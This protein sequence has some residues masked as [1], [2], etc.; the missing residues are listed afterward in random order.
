MI[1]EPV[2]QACQGFIQEE[3]FELLAIVGNFDDRFLIVK[4]WSVTFSL[5]TLAL[6]FQK[7][8]NGLLFVA[9][10]SALS[11]WVLEASMKAHQLG[12]YPRMRQIEVLC[13]EDGKA[14]PGVDWAWAQAE[15][16]LEGRQ[17]E[18]EGPISQRREENLPFSFLGLHLSVLW[19]PH[20]FLPHLVTL[21]A[22]VFCFFWYRK[23]RP[24]TP[25]PTKGTDP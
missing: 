19:F 9:A 21:A 11:F 23:G 20:V 22:A 13:N 12:Y 8:S 6:A 10:L 1:P 15:E 3:Y 25:L 18:I 4:G 17:S 2:K 16:L 24:V 5:A 14:A 7:R